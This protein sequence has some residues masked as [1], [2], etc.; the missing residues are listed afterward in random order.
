MGGA[1][2]GLLLALPSFFGFGW[3]FLGEGYKKI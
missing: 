1:S 2:V 3:N